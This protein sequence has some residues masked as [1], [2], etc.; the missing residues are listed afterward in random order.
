[1]F[2]N[3]IFSFKKSKIL[4]K[5][6]KNENKD[7]DLSNLT[8]SMVSKRKIRT[9][10]INDLFTLLKKDIQTDQ[11]LKHYNRDFEDLQKIIDKLVLNGAGQ[12]IK[13]H[14]V[15]IS[16]ISFLDTLQILLQYW[17]GENFQVNDYDEYN[18]NLF[19]SNKMLTSF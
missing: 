12:T 1:M 18:S 7:I 13:G 9:E 8:S 4:S 10:L 16:A 19:I 17:N 3:F 5:I 2:K 14:Y 6:A 15:P 11:L